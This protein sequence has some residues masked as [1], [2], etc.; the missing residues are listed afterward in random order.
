MRKIAFVRWIG[1]I[2]AAERMRKIAFVRWIGAFE[3]RTN[4]KN[5]IR[6]LDWGHRVPNEC[7]K[8]HSFGGLGPSSAERMRKIALVRRIGAFEVQR[9]S[10]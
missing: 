7:E 3:C 4:A 2:E 9:V 1:A 5:R 10:V 6:S 8:S